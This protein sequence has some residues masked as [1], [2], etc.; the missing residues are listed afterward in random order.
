MISKKEDKIF[1]IVTDLLRE[2]ISK[3]E[4]IDKLLILHSVSDCQFETYAR[5]CIECDRKGMKPLKHKDYGELL[6]NMTLEQ[7]IAKAKPNL[8]KIKDVDKHIEDIR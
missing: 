2:D 1:D 7:V 5:F 8:D 3:E 4:A 6:P